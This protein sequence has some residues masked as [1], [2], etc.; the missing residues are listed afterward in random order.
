MFSWFKRKEPEDATTL[1]VRQAVGGQSVLF[2]LFRDALS[3]AES[4]IDK[5]ELTYFTASVMTFTYLLVRKP[6]NPAAA[7]N[8]FTEQ[9]L[10]L[11]ADH[12]GQTFDDV[13]RAYQ[14][15]YRD[16]LA[17]IPEVLRRENAGTTMHAEALLHRLY[18]LVTGESTRG[19]LLV[20]LTG[21]RLVAQFVVDSVDFMR[22][23]LPRTE[24]RAPERAHSGSVGVTDARR[25]NSSGDILE[26]ELKLLAPILFPGGHPEIAAAG[27][28][29]SGLLDN[30]V[31][32]D[33]A[34]RLFASTRYLAHTAKDKSK[35][36]VVAYIV[37]QG[38]GRI[39]DDDAGVGDV[40]F[41]VEPC[42]MTAPHS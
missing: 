29:I 33:A 27:R 1:L 32:A 10:R 31:P 11:A 20:T 23:G 24:Q 41:V 38:M 5:L 12:N 9:F 2:R 15:R 18:E 13:A 21:T 35:Q 28:S 40:P 37:R 30:R 16:Y 42:R 7:I 8:P 22:N 3:V 25:A 39:S 6:V 4:R 36:R 14:G 26:G 34:A 17:L 19:Q